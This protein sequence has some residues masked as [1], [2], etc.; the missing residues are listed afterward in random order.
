MNEVNI[1]L[2]DDKYRDAWNSFIKISKNGHFF[3]YREYMEY[4]AD[5]F[6][7]FSMLCFDRKGNVIAVIPASK[8]G[9]VLISHGGLTFG[10]VISDEKMSTEK[11]LAIF[12]E[13]IS[14]C[15]FNG[16]RKIL[17]K[18]IPYIYSRYPSEEDRYA[19]FINGAKLIRRDV[20]TAICL[21]CRYK[22]KKLRKR[23]I[24]KAHKSGMNVRES[25]DYIS[26]INLV[27]GVLE[28]YHDTSAVHSGEELELLA[29]RFPDNIHLY[30]AESDGDMLAGT[31]VFENNDVVHTQYLANSDA[32]RDVGALDLVIDYL[33]TEKYTGYAYLDFGIS[34][35][36]QGRY[37]NKGL[38]EQK[39]GF[40]GRAIVH[41]FYELNI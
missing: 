40:G 41:D 23:M 17:Y 33:I 4:H 19:L 30:I 11:M 7:D 28:K 37:L 34:N 13:L 1:V 27:N 18:C 12:S 14:I 16:I 38:I 9:D 36:Q 35:E 10:G 21:P 2:Y 8:D 3:F 32:G 15:K 6:N 25:N 20:S 39:E 26:F 24:S 5:R 29:S 31:V 22:Y